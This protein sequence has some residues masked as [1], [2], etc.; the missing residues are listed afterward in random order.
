MGNPIRVICVCVGTKFDPS[1]VAILYDMV[2]RNLSKDYT[3]HVITDRDMPNA[4][5]ADTGL[6]GWWQK[7]K[8]FDPSL[9]FDKGDRMVY[10]DLDVAITGDLTELVETKGI[11]RDWNLPGF[12]S[13]VMV[14][15]HGEHAN[16]WTDFYRPS[17]HELDGDQDWITAVSHL[18]DPWVIFPRDWFLS[19]RAHAV[20]YPPRGCVAV[21]FHGAPKPHEITDGW[22][23]DVWK[24]GGLTELPVTKGM[25]ISYGDALANIETNSK[26]DLPW[27]MGAHPHKRTAVV[28][29]GAPSLRHSI[30]AINAHRQRGAKIIALNNAGK[31][32]NAHGIRPDVVVVLD[33]RPEN[34]NFTEAKA[35]CFLIASQCDPSLLEALRDHP[36]VILWHAYMCNEME[37]L[38]SP[39]METHPICALGGGGTVFLRALGLLVESG[40]RKIHAYGVDSCYHADEHHSYDQSLND[41]DR[42][43]QVTV[44]YLDGATYR[45]APW[46]SRQASEFWDEWPN[47]IEKGVK[48]TVHGTGLIPDLW[49]KLK[50][51]G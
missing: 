35:D 5:A 34:I 16:V 25:N 19:Y 11:I 42:P 50:D 43:M 4:I 2:Q 51:A 29:G 27:F 10:F 22:V 23:P 9:P 26:L 12:N 44:P 48:L 41:T 17:M 15:D 24:L 6:P 33:A 8:L 30:D 49:R 39:Y 21:I 1:Y 20:D 45:C 46:M 38:L 18:A 32:L 37:D 36:N 31:Y 28:V 14:W 47:L 3:F 13:S 7:V 40:H